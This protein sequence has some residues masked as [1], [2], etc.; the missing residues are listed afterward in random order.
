[1]EKMLLVF[2][3]VPYA[4]GAEF[5]S[6]RSVCNGLEYSPVYICIFMW[7]TFLLYS[8]WFSYSACGY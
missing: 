8:A 5:V 4:S 6:V 1:M 3:G 2:Y 7:L